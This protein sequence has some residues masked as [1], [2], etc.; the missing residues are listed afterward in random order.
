MKRHP[1]RTI[2]VQP[3]DLGPHSGS[4]RLVAFS[5]YRVQDIRRLLEEVARLEPRPD[6]VL[7][8]GDDIQR[9]HPSSRQNLFEE[10]ASKC[11]PSDFPVSGPRTI[12]S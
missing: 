6:L 11:R 3:L 8:A 1:K 12:G 2:S 9:F 7:Y 10:F 4:L 5:D